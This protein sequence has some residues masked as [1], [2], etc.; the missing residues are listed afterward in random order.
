M[1]EQPCT[2]PP[3]CVISD[4]W[5]QGHN[6]T[7]PRQNQGQWPGAPLEE[8]DGMGSGKEQGGAL[9]AGL[10]GCIAFAGAGGWGVVGEA[11]RGCAGAG[12][13]RSGV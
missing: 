7:N 5:P 2:P 9:G 3:F 6:P 1:P 8:K 13:L 4:P 12:G 10:L 11:C